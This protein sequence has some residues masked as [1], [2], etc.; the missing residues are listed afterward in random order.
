M[1]RIAIF[2]YII[3]AFAAAFEIAAAAADALKAYPKVIPAQG[4]GSGARRPYLSHATAAHDVRGE[5]RRI[6]GGVS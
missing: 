4:G 3:T 5:T 2:T 1:R 6:E